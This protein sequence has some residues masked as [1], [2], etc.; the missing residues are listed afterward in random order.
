MLWRVLDV[1]TSSIWVKCKALCCILCVCVAQ[2]EM[3]VT[4][5][6]GNH[7]SA[8][9]EEMNQKN[10]NKEL[11]NCCAEWVYN[12]NSELVSNYTRVFHHRSWC[13]LN[14]SFLLAVF[15]SL[16]YCYVKVGLVIWTFK[17]EGSWWTCYIFFLNFS[18]FM[19][20]KY[21]VLLFPFACFIYLYI[22][23]L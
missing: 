21:T 15:C 1:H 5:V 13:M 23:Y 11:F 12:Y 9:K 20:V 19:V 22:F 8:V 2:S 17:K 6:N 7:V 3:F 10:S 14:C 18:L 4:H 16:C